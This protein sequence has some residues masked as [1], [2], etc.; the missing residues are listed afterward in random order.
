[1]FVLE[2]VS[3]DV[4]IWRE[5]KYILYKCMLLFRFK[6]VI[7]YHFL[8]LLML[9]SS[10]S[11]TKATTAH[12]TIIRCYRLS[13]FNNRKVFLTVLEAGSPRSQWQQGWVLSE[14]PLLGLQVASTLLY[15]HVIERERTSP[16][17]SSFQGTNS[18]HKGSTLM[19]SSN[20][21]LSLS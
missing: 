18:H 9:Y 16:L 13:G 20:P 19:T 14:N 15:P 8:C 12:A 3:M 7:R 11:I 6:I 10:Q 1:M 17:V 21:S 2:E 4:N 5:L